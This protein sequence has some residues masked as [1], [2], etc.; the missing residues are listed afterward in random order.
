LDLQG[1]I[2]GAKEEFGGEYLCPSGKKYFASDAGSGCTHLNGT[3]GRML[4]CNKKKGEWAN[5]WVDCAH[6][7]MDHS[8]AKDDI[9]LNHKKGKTVY[10]GLYKCPSGRVYAVGTQDVNCK[11]LDA[12]GGKMLSCYKKR[13]PWTYRGVDCAGP[14]AVGH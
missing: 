4:N 14:V 3:G 2:P 9:V 10:G 13:G 8:I 5:R 11:Y 7:G 1:E 6:D 12:K